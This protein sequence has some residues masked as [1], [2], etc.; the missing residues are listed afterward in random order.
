[1]DPLEGGRGS[2]GS[3]S[4]EGAREARKSHAARLGDAA[5]EGN[6]LERKENIVK[7]KRKKRSFS[8]TTPRTGGDQSPR[9]GSTA[10]PRGEVLGILTVIGWLKR[11]KPRR[12]GCSMFG[13]IG[14]ETRK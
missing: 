10:S 9:V 6:S 3:G 8:I 13:T 14:W 7:K 11:K 1:M 12:K 5:Y 4:P 2:H